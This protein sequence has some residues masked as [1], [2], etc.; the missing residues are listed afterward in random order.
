[1]QLLTQLICSL[2]LTLALELVWVYFF[3]AR[4]KDLLLFVLVNIL[5]NPAAVLISVFTGYHLGIQILL[6]AV[7]VLAEGWYYI[8]YADFMKCRMCCSLCANGFS[9]LVGVFIQ[10]IRMKYS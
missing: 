10:L 7:V 9:Y 8:R 3:G 6:E 5:T 4:K 2:A 1:M